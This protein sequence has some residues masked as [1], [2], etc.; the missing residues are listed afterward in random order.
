M[1]R[2]AARARARARGAAGSPVR[3]GARPPAVPGAAAPVA[4]AA[5]GTRALVQK[6]ETAPC[7]LPLQRKENTV[8]TPG[9]HAA[10]GL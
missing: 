3:R 1:D 2:G 10:T 8:R 4:A 5:A 7:H 9:S 6:E